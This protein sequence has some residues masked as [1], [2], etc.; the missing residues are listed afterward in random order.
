MSLCTLTVNVTLK[1][2]TKNAGN[3]LNSGIY[4]RHSQQE[5]C[6]ATLRISK[7]LKTSVRVAAAFALLLAAAPRDQSKMALREESRGLLVYR[8]CWS[9]IL[10]L[11]LGPDDECHILR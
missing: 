9:G 3:P 10:S 7:S 2:P 8:R 11:P 4:W 1:I 6:V 5:A